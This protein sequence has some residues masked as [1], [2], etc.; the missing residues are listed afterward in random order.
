MEA[1]TYVIVAKG[2]RVE[3]DLHAR[4]V[5]LGGTV[6]GDIWAVEVEIFGGGLC[7]GRIEAIKINEETKKG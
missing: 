2:A 7:R 5:Y 6:E 3:G 1:K 4:E